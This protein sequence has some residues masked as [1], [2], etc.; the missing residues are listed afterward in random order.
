MIKTKKEKEEIK[1]NRRVETEEERKM[2]DK[3]RYE[4]NRY[5]Y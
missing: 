4:M 1:M 5:E 2:I 3:I